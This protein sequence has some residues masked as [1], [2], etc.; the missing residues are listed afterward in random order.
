VAAKFAFTEVPLV[1]VLKDTPLVPGPVYHK[2]EV[3]S[4][5][6]SILNVSPLKGGQAT[7]TPVTTPG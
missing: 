1:A 5:T 2:Y 4:A 7:V 6:G 3:A